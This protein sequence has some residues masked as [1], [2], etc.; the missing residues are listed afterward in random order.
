M[1]NR[2]VIP[3]NLRASIMT[4]KRYGL[5]GRDTMIRGMAD[6]WWPKIHREVINSARFCGDCSQ[7]G[8]NVKLLQKQSEYGKIPWSLKPNE[9]IAGP[10]KNDKYEKNIFASVVR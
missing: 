8:K 2:L 9:E 5:P 4:A 6:T 3:L 7:E 10:F 1:D